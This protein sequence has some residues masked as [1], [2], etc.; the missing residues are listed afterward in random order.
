MKTTLICV[1][2]ACSLA[3]LARAEATAKITKV[4]LC[5]KSCVT[6][7][8]KAVG[9]VDGATVAV[10]K[11]EGTVSLTGPDVATVQKAADELVAAGYFGTTTDPHV[12]LKADTGAKGEKVQSLQVS[13]VH[14]R[15]MRQGGG[16]GAQG[17]PRSE[18]PERRER[19]E[20]FRSD[21]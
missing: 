13:G 18:G 5:C 10:D 2:M 4:H 12:K 11:D 1:L 20:E 9:K 15:Q 19:R 8:E 17:C 3:S 6:G 21:R 7:V 14:L 16:G